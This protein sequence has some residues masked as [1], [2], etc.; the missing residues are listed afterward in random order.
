MLKGIFNPGPLF[1]CELGKEPN[2]KMHKA[3]LFDSWPQ[4]Y[5]AWFQ[6]PIGR[7][8]KTYEAKTVLG[9]LKPGRGEIILDA[10][11]GTGIFTLDFLAA[12][13]RIVG[14]EISWPMLITARRKVGGEPFEE[15]LGDMIKLPFK[16]NRFDKAVSVTALEFIEDAKGAVRELFRV[17]KPGGRVVVATLNSLSP[18]AD[19]RKAKTKRGEK[20][21][22]EKAYFRS[23]QEISALAPYPCKIQTAIHFKKDEKPAR[24]GEI[25]K[26]G[27]LKKSDSGAFVAA[28]WEKP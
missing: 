16:E 5:D 25:E 12:G 2:K 1:L 24:A 15:I 21:V 14:L 28:S 11:C 23:P 18:W 26:Q 27:F 4:R 8:V 3:K 7:L 17:T 10:G 6:T 20:H 19:R 13:A 9:L 22:L